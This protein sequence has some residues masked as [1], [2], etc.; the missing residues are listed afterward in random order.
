MCIFIKK[1]IKLITYTKN[2]SI[3]IFR[4]L[5]IKVKIFIN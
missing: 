3:I 2:K 5:I 4:N 1:L